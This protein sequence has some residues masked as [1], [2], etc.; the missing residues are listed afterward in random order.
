MCAMGIKLASV[1]A[2]F[3]LHFGTVSTVCYSCFLFSYSHWMKDLF[4]CFIEGEWGKY[5]N[6]TNKQILV[7]DSS[8][9]ILN[10]A[11]VIPFAFLFYTI[12]V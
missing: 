9:F 5:L 12:L 6:T 4:Y 7:L 2:V 3:P 1:S 8:L 10:F 11:F